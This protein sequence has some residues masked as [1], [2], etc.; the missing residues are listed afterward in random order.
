MIG[1]SAFAALLALGSIT[2]APAHAQ[3]TPEPD[4]IKVTRTPL[5]DLRIDPR[6][7]P[8]VLRGAHLP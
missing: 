3:A 1:P 5:R 2:M 7:I 6:Y 8:A 4:A